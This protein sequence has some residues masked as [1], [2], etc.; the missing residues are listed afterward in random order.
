MPVLPLPLQVLGCEQEVEC[1][2]LERAGAKYCRAQGEWQA[3]LQGV[4]QLLYPVLYCTVLYSSI[5]NCTALYCILL[6]WAL[7]IVL[8]STVN[9][10]L[11]VSL[12]YT[13]LHSQYY[14]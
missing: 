1:R 4:S 11:R 6:Y 13:A 7:F 3:V 10:L 5:L 12:Q 2:A 14:V 9:C 8:Y